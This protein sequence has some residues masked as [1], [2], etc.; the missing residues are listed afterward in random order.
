MLLHNNHV[1]TSW[2][3]HVTISLLDTCYYL[4][5]K[6]LLH[7]SG[8]RWSCINIGMC[9]CI[10]EMMLYPSGPMLVYHDEAIIF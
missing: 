4:I 9:S 1:V 8:D 5:V 2:C 7:H 10:S 6:M 3:R